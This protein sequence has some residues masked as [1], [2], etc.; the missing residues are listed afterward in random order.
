MTSPCKHSERQPGRHD[1]VFVSPDGWRA[2]LDS[3]GDL[4][5][6]VL[7]ARWPKMRWPTIRR[8]ALPSEATGLALGLPLPPSAGKKRISLV[9]D[10]DH[11]ASVARPPSLRQAR[12]YAPRSWWLTLD[13]L[14]ELALRHAV[15]ARVFGS[16]AWQSL[17]GLDYVTGRSDLDILFEV[18]GETDVDRF[19]AEVAAIET[20]APMR[21]DGELMGADGAAV[22]WR[23]FHGGADEIL[24]KSIER[25]A[26]LGRDQ[27]ISGAMGS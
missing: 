27:F 25:A 14:D 2:I 4:A 9:V 7:V 10:I 19:V 20:G 1:L 3:R 24:V 21:L 18:Q 11:V 8:R 13:R 22:N 12:A 23:E 15:D 5:T 6:D 26:L 17:T 16:L